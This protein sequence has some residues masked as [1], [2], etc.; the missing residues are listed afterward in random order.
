MQMQSCIDEHKALLAKGNFDLKNR[1]DKTEDYKIRKK[2]EICWKRKKICRR[3]EYKGL[4]I[5]SKDGSYCWQLV[6]KTWF[7]FPPQFKKSYTAAKP[8]CYNAEIEDPD[9]SV[10]A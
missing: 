4:S 6:Q 3:K 7:S 1:V 2:R 5:L 9:D 8:N 10:S